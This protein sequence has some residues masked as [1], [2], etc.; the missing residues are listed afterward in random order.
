MGLW[1]RGD[2][3]LGEPREGDYERPLLLVFQFPCWEMLLQ[4][5]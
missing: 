4:R 3:G 1:E 2:H 5:M